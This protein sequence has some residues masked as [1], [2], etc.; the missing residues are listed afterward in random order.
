MKGAHAA[1][2]SIEPSTG[3]STERV[4]C[5]RLSPR[6]QRTQTKPC[7]PMAFK[8]PL[9]VALLASAL[10]A[11]ASADVLIMKDGRIFEGFK[12]AQ[13]DDSVT[14]TLKAGT[15][16]V[17]MDLVDI[18]LIDGKEIEFNPQTDEE[19][20]KFEEGWVHFNDKWTKISNAKRAIEKELKQRLKDAKED[21]KRAQ[22]GKRYVTETKYF[23]WNHT[24]PMRVTQRFID[25]ADAYYKVFKKDWKIKRDKGKEKLKINFYANRKDYHT[26]SGAPGGALAY[27]MFLGDYDLCAF[28]DRLD[29]DFT[30][31]VVFHELGHYLHKLI[32]EEFNYPHWPGESLSEYYGGAAFE[33]G[34]LQVGLI[35]NG[36]LATIKGEMERGDK[37]ELKK[38]I[39]TR[40]FEDYTWGWSFVHY[41][42]NQ[43]EH[44]DNFKKFFI[45]LAKDRTV[46]R[47]RDG[48]NLKNV[49]GEEVL[50]YFMETM[51]IADEDELRELEK[52]WYDYINE[53]LDFSGDNALIWEAKTA[54]NLG[55]RK[56]AAELYKKAFKEGMDSAPASAHYD[57][58]QLLGNSTSEE[59]MKHLRMA[60]QKAPLTA[61]FRYRLGDTLSDKKGKKAEEGAMH[62]ALAI[63][64]D[65]EV[66]RNMFVFQF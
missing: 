30:E 40:G 35:H 46:K 24:T 6:T 21:V 65:P 5:A 14:V 27:F 56:R 19:K 50:R 49:S 62:K 41:L 11:S 17:K 31:Q 34:K 22:W 8:A 2:L 42:M 57:Y 32:D 15:I 61:T 37:I 38:M 3:T 45:G 10:T 58:Y 9:A 55:E 20:E 29:A 64:L 47:Q 59:A 66:D 23:E 63:E 1:P 43:K 39:T 26:G 7:K 44:A 16:D 54:K 25:S 52:K 18:V 36:R 60:V 51:K 33:D 28:Y 48:R 53:E 13:T 4:A 12:L